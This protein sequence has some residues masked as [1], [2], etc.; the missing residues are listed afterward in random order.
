MVKLN[1]RQ[2]IVCPAASAGILEGSRADVSFAAG[3][4]VDKFAYHLPVYRQHQRLADS[5]IPVSHPWLTQIAQQVIGLLEPI[6]KAQ[7]ASIRASRVKP[8]DETPIKAGW[9]EPGRLQAAYFWPVYGEGGEVCFPFFESRRREHVE[10]ALGKTAVPGGVL[11][12]DGYTHLLIHKSG[13]A[14]T[15]KSHRM[16]SAQP[17]RPAGDENLRVASSPKP[18]RRHSV[19]MCVTRWAIP[20]TRATPGRSG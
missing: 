11:L 3:L 4:L 2:T 17:S 14:A 15:S 9:S 13:D 18:R 8:M 6:N 19:E 10:Q 7:F 20:R 12:S 5:G 1:N 16:S